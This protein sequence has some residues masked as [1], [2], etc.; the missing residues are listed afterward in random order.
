VIP[1]MVNLIGVLRPTSVSGER[2]SHADLEAKF[3]PCT[4][5]FTGSPATRSWL[6][7]V[8]PA[9]IRCLLVYM[10]R[11]SDIDR[12]IDPDAK[13]WLDAPFSAETW[14]STH[15]LRR[16]NKMQSVS[17]PHVNK[18]EWNTFDRYE[19]AAGEH[20]SGGQAQFDRC[21]SFGRNHVLWW[22]I[23][24]AVDTA[25]VDTAAVD[26]AAVDTA[27]RQHR[28]ECVHHRHGA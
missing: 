1:N 13:I 17:P 8:P 5:Q 15:G 6:A 3:R 7:P 20:E 14:A 27:P 24:T 25:A 18:N 23:A 10:A 9:P 12:L 28:R 21:S 4:A 2:R 16:L 22:L 26:T 11:G 19:S